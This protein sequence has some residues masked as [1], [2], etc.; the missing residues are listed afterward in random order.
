MP[1]GRKI[2]ESSNV[3]ELILD[4]HGAPYTLGLFPEW[5]RSKIS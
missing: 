3:G 1:F 4:K 2:D 5:R